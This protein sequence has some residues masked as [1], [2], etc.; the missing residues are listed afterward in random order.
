MLIR[1]LVLGTRQGV[2]GALLGGEFW[3]RGVWG[4]IRMVVFGNGG[5]CCGRVV[6]VGVGTGVKVVV[7]EGGVLVCG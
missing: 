2:L 7:E 1:I 3:L 5:G 6:V 4:R